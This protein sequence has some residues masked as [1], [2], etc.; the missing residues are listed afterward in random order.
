MTLGFDIRKATGINDMILARKLIENYMHELG[1]DLCFQGV[2]E[3]LDNLPGPY[4][5]PDGVIYF[6]TLDGENIASA[7]IALKRLDVDA[8]EM[9]RLYVEPKHRGLG[10]G[11]ALVKCLLRAAKQ[12]EYSIMRLDTLARL[13]S[14]IAIYESHGFTKIE[15]YNNAPLEGITYFEKTLK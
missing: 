9:K 3:E 5:E 13:K 12:K 10:M 15:A 14:A 11:E 1:E 6:A 4:A 8:C 2:N 7:M